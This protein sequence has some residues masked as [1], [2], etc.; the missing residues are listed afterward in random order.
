M[1]REHRVERVLQTIDLNRKDKLMQ[2][3]ESIRQAHHSCCECEGQMKKGD[4]SP[5][6][7]LQLGYGTLILASQLAVAEQQLNLPVSERVVS[8]VVSS[9]AEVQRPTLNR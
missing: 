8:Q 9:D 1:D 4:H 6:K 2:L 3:A 7:A 5:V